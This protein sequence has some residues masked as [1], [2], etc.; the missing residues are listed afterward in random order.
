SDTVKGRTDGPWGDSDRRTSGRELQTDGLW[1][2]KKRQHWVENNPQMD[3]GERR[4][5]EHWGEKDRQT[6]G[7]EIQKITVE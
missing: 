6:L 7:I 5:E 2:E 3:I 4:T 1:A